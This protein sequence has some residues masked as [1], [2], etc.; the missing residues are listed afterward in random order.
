MAAVSVVPNPVKLAEKPA[1][2]IAIDATIRQTGKKREDLPNSKLAQIAATV[3]SQRK[4]TNHDK[5]ASQE[6]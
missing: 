5:H 1:K 3:E 2:T 4:K 6:L